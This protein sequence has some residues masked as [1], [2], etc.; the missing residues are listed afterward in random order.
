MSIV[1]SLRWARFSKPDDAGVATD[2]HRGTQSAHV[3]TPS[4]MQCK[5]HG[6]D[7]A[8]VRPSFALSA[9][10]VQ[11]V[12]ACVGRLGVVDRTAT[13]GLAPARADPSHATAVLVLML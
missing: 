9:P 7:R 3:R 11:C 8:D 13:K 4:G 10:P 2:T 1:P 6:T 12:L 5:T